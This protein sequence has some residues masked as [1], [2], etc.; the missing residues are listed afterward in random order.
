MTRLA[1]VP[2]VQLQLQQQQQQQVQRRQAN[3][4]ITTKMEDVDAFNYV[5]LLNN[6]FILNYYTSVVQL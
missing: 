3:N 5:Y 4:T 6:V 2:S 1:V